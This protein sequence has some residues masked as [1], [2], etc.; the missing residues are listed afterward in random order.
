MAYPRGEAA[1]ELIGILGSDPGRS[2][3]DL[4]LKG[5]VSRYTTEGGH[6]GI[7]FKGKRITLKN[8][9]YELRKRGSAVGLGWDYTTCSL[10]IRASSG[11]K[12]QNQIDK[13]LG[14]ARMTLDEYDRVCDLPDPEL[15]VLHPV[16]REL[17]RR[18]KMTGVIENCHHAEVLKRLARTAL[19]RR[20]MGAKV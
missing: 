9:N 10:D 20:S 15:L 7:V 3:A 16:D 8:V 17:L 6:P 14:T 11:V 13:V 5:R 18:F 2:F 4:E 19:I 12:Q 1:R